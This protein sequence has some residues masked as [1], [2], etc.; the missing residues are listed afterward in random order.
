M[1]RVGL[2]VQSGC[3][4]EAMPRIGEMEKSDQWQFEQ[5]PKSALSNGDGSGS[6]YII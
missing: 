2:E 4:E 3:Y 1:Q 5:K 6:K